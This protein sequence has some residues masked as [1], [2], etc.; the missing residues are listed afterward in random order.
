MLSMFVGAMIML[1]APAAPDELLPNKSNARGIESPELLGVRDWALAI[2][3]R[4]L[5]R[6]NGNAHAQIVAAR[7]LSAIPMTGLTDDLGWSAPPTVAAEVRAM[8][9]ANELLAASRMIGSAADKGLSRSSVGLG[10]RLVPIEPGVGAAV[11]IPVQSGEA[12][13][14]AAGSGGA[15]RLHITLSDSK[16]NILCEN[17]WVSV[18]T[19]RSVPRASGHYLIRARVEAYDAGAAALAIPGDRNFAFVP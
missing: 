5:A 16:G 18:V 3:M 2:Q 9:T 12:V 13:T 7:I 11:R 15:S 4:A 1:A 17:S 10:I 14:I 6:K 8:T 19:C